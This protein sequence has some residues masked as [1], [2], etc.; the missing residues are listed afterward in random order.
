MNRCAKARAGC[1]M[2]AGDRNRH[3]RM[4]AVGSSGVMRSSETLIGPILYGV[5]GVADIST[6]ARAL[7]DERADFAGASP[8]SSA[9]ASARRPLT[10]MIAVPTL[11]IGAADEGAVDLARTLTGAGHRALVVSRGGRL[12]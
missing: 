10:V 1:I 6:A 9:R 2:P 11:E 4:T 7:I 8:A 12:E 3:C 5:G